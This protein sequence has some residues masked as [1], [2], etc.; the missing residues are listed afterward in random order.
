MEAKKFRKIICTLFLTIG[1]LMVVTIL[2]AAQE[3]GQ[4]VNQMDMETRNATLPPA[5]TPVTNLPLSGDLPLAGTQ[6]GSYPIMS[7]STLTGSTGMSGMGMSG[8]MP[9]MQ[10]MSGMN[11]TM[12]YYAKPWY[13]NPWSLL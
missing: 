12:P 2:A 5:V 13:E 4:E 3:G 9:A 6:T 7:G 1:L 10:G 11:G 8:S